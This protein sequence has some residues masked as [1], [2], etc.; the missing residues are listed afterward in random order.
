VTYRELRTR[1]H[2]AYLGYAVFSRGLKKDEVEQFAEDIN[3][4][5]SRLIDTAPNLPVDFPQSEMVC[6]I[7]IKA[8]SFQRIG[9]SRSEFS[10]SVK[11]VTREAFWGGRANENRDNIEDLLKSDTLN[12]QSTLIQIACEAMNE[13]VQ[14]GNAWFAHQFVAIEALDN[15][16]TRRPDL[17]EKWLAPILRQEGVATKLIVLGRSFYEALCE[18]VLTKMP[19]KGSHLYRE[20]DSKNSAIRF[21]VG[22]TRIPLLEHALFRSPP[23]E[24]VVEVWNDKLRRCKTDRELFELAISAQQ[25]TAI[26]WLWT[27]ID[28]GLASPVLIDRARS[29]MLLGFLD[30]DR[31][32]GQLQQRRVSEPEIWVDHIIRDA[33]FLWQKNSWAKHWFCR[34][35][36]VEN[37]IQSWASFRL[38]LKCADRRFWIWQKEFPDATYSGN[39]WEFFRDNLEC[40]SREIEKN[41]KSLAETFLGQKVLANQVWPWI[42]LG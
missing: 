29:A 32:K 34:F 11:F 37:E 36:T 7:S 13:Q 20:L 25:G 18:I 42:N 21:L 19:E 12:E 6:D 17:M 33:W 9:L 22:P 1:I 31:A 10:R 30:G 27:R 28:Q 35:L 8:K 41:E 24:G 16:V 39:R 38:F 4:I 23:V 15:L 40:V 26:T 5:W 14:A 2:P 3:R